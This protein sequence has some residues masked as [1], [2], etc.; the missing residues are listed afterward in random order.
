VSQWQL[1]DSARACSEEAGGTLRH[2][3]LVN[4]SN[5]DL[6][7]AIMPVN[8]TP[9]SEKRRPLNL[10]GKV[11]SPHTSEDGHLTVPWRWIAC[12]K[13]CVRLRVVKR[14]T[15]F[16]ALEPLRQAVRDTKFREGV[17]QFLVVQFPLFGSL[18]C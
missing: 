14:A 11:G 12:T 5:A 1:H 16:E 13:E 4:S 17:S 15:R 8:A 9:N 3:A 7:K 6:I 18:R 2:L 10:C